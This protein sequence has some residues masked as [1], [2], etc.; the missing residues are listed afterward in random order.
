MINFIMI[1]TRG[2]KIWT[3]KIVKFGWNYVK[4]TKKKILNISLKTSN[5]VIHI[6]TN[7]YIYF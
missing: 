2:A 7:K 6:I 4:Y 1:R 5:D 3:K